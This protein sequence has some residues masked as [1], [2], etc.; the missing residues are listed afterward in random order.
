MALIQNIKLTMDLANADIAIHLK[1]LHKSFGDK[2][3]LN[4]FNL[5]LKRGENVVVLGKS[6]S[7][8]SIL[9]KCIIG[10]V[11]PDKGEIEIFGQNT[12]KLSPK[13]MD[14]IRSKMGFLFQSNAL[15]DSMTVRENLEFPLK[16][17]RI[18]KS[19]EII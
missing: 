19:K 9:I 10:L 4:G 16:R 11:P 8:K 3:I 18:S 6:G 17:L 7:G 15:Y 1:D 14:I 2:H 13:D 12:L 5:T